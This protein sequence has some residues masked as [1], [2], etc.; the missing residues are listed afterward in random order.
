MLMN[1]TMQKVPMVNRYP[2]CNVLAHKDVFGS[3][4]KFANLLHPQAFDFIPQT[5]TLPNAQESI[6]L[7]AYMKAHPNAT[8]I[9]KP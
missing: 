8:Y 4:M 6:R 9:A 1:T 5:F 7:E 3:M 2:D